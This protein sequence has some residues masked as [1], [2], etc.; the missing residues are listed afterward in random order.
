M[1][2]ASDQYHDMEDE[3]TSQPVILGETFPPIAKKEEMNMAD[4]LVTCNFLF[5]DA[6]QS[7]NYD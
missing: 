2:E 5:R 6:Y 3:D 1:E 7:L 4:V